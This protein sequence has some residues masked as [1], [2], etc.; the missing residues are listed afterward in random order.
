M[1]IFNKCYFLLAILIF[2]IEVVIALFIKDNFIRPYVGDVLV[3]IMIYCFLK[4]FVRIRV[5]PA[6]LIVL[7]FAFVVE[8]MQWIQVVDRLGIDRSSVLGIVI[9]SSFSWMDMMAYVVGIGIVIIYIHPCQLQ[10]AVRPSSSG[11]NV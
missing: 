5:I 4:T 3:V 2:C 9:G 7:V 1:L 10:V 8:F 11:S 6:A